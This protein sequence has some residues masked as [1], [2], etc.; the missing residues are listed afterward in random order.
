MEYERA[1]RSR[2]RE[3]TFL[4]SLHKTPSL[5]VDLEAITVLTHRKL[6]Y[7]I[8]IV[9]KWFLHHIITVNQRLTN[10]PPNRALNDVLNSSD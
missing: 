7:G 8:L 10:L 6:H 9:D 5:R 2:E 3:D 4:A 1:W